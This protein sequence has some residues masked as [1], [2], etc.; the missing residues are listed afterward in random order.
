[1]LLR[2][3]VFSAAGQLSRTFRAELPRDVGSPGG[4][5][6]DIARS[7]VARWPP[8]RALHRPGRRSDSLGD[9]DDGS[10]E[11]LVALGPGRCVRGHLPSCVVRRVPR[12]TVRVAR[13]KT[14]IPMALLCVRQGARVRGRRRERLA[15]IDTEAHAGCSI[16]SP[17]GRIDS[18]RIIVQ[19]R[20]TAD[21]G[22]RGGLSESELDGVVE[23]GLSGIPTRLPRSRRTRPHADVEGTGP[24]LPI[25]PVLRSVHVDAQRGASGSRRSTTW[26]GADPPP[27][28]VFAADG[29]HGSGRVSLARRDSTGGSSSTAFARTWRSATDYVLGVWTDELDVQYVR[30]YRLDR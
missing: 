27:F 11:R 15:L 3:Q 26:P 4:S 23:H 12:S 10:N 17:A 19:R 5:A 2:I 25:L 24:G 8:H 29:V 21:R 13:W 14:T 28:E 20:C 22:D 7:G 18:M 1:M 30:M 16:V 6:A 9:R